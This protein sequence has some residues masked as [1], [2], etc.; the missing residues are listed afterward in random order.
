MAVKIIFYVLSVLLKVCIFGV[1]TF[2]YVNTSKLIK[3]LPVSRDMYWYQK[4]ECF[5]MFIVAY[6]QIVIPLNIA[7]KPY[8]TTLIEFVLL[9]VVYTHLN[10]W[11]WMGKRILICRT[12]QFN[13]K[14]LNN[15]SYEKRIL[16]FTSGSRQFTLHHPL[17]TDECI[18]KYL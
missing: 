18:K 14:R 8:L 3:K 4:A 7:H 12:E 17:L 1:Y 2:D 5:I 6:L 11:L 15:V 10:R 16:K 13:P 9:I